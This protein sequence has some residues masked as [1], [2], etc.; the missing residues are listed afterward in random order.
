M[1]HDSEGIWT[2]LE[3]HHIWFSPHQLRSRRNRNHR[4]RR[5]AATALVLVV[6]A[7]QYDQNKAGT[8]PVKFLW[9]FKTSKGSCN[10][11]YTVFIEVFSLHRSAKISIT[12]SPWCADCPITWQILYDDPTSTKVLDI[13]ACTR[14]HHIDTKTTHPMLVPSCFAVAKSR[15]TS[16]TAF[17]SYSQV[18]HNWLVSDGLLHTTVL[19][20]SSGSCCYSG[21]AA[22]KR[23]GCTA[24]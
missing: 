22:W 11:N 20:T 13:T 6:A 14:A 23:T 17:L 19:V 15:I 8:T 1:Y 5:S 10:K 18:Q 16:K 12:I 2:V 7:N 24:A 9:N 3:P 21:F 4:H